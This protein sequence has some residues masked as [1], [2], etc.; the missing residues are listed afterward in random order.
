MKGILSISTAS[1]EELT[2]YDYIRPSLKQ[3]HISV[4][5]N[6]NKVIFLPKL[7][8][9]HRPGILSVTLK[10]QGLMF[11]QGI[12]PSDNWRPS[13]KVK[14][15]HV[16]KGPTFDPPLKMHPYRVNNN[17]Y[18]VFQVEVE[19]P[20]E[21]NAI[22]SQDAVSM[23]FLNANYLRIEPSSTA[24]FQTIFVE[25]AGG[26][27]QAAYYLAKSPYRLFLETLSDNSNKNKL[28]WLLEHPSK[29]RAF[30]HFDLWEIV[31][32]TIPQNTQKYYRDISD[33]LPK[34]VI[35]L[36]ERRLL[37]RGFFLSCTSCSFRSW[38]PVDHIG[39]SFTCARCFQNQIYRSNP[40]W[41]Y[42]L[43]EIIFQGF[44]NAM[45]VPLL[46]LNY[47][48]RKSRYH[49]DWIPDSDIFW[50]EEQKE[51]SRN[52]DIICICDGEMYIG[53]AKSA[54]SI[55]KDQF[56]FYQGV[57][58]KAA[59]DGVIFA[60]SQ[61][62]WDKKTLGYIETL[63]QNFSGKVLCLTEEDLYPEK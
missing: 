13:Q 46:T 20:I 35:A 10:W 47:M 7:P 52:I 29:R 58:Q 9:E 12:N 28:G 6:H 34:E 56:S 32:E 57:C 54:A 16:I 21:I 63:K 38:Y 8:Q 15:D 18:L 41:L 14:L 30:N 27:D 61:K 24:N 51:L 19:I 50:I 39:Q 2:F 25:R 48:K 59:I 3:E 4:L 37:E 45:Q 43:P 17:H 23:I 33:K 60:T 11:P 62:H 40:L 36:L 22:S 26:L 53:E 5:N 55:E 44:N 31:G 1:Y 49:F 42:K